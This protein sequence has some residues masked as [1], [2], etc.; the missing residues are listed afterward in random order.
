[1]P[2]WPGFEKRVL[3]LR[4]RYGAPQAALKTPTAQEGAKPAAKARKSAASATAFSVALPRQLP[5]EFEAVVETVRLS[6]QADLPKILDASLAPRKL[7][8][9][10]PAF[11]GRYF[12]IEDGLSE[13]DHHDRAASEG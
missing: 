13:V 8:D 10:T 3:A 6:V 9:Q 11:I 1:M 5:G 4:K 2:D 7:F 12:W